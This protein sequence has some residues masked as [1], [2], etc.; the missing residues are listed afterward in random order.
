MSDKYQNL[1]DQLCYIIFFTSLF[2]FFIFPA[3]YSNFDEFKYS[4]IKGVILGSI[5]WSIIW[6]SIDF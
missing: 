5:I 2:Y 4:Y 3:F 1:F 6:L